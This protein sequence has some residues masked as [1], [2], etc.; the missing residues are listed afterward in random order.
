MSNHS[1]VRNL[2]DTWDLSCSDLKQETEKLPIRKYGHKTRTDREMQ[3]TLELTQTSM[4]KKHEFNEHHQTIS[5]NN[6]NIITNH[7]PCHD[8]VHWQNVKFTKHCTCHQ[9]G[10][11]EY[12]Q[13]HKTVANSFH[14]PLKTHQQYKP[15]IWN[16]P[17]LRDFLKGWKLKTSAQNLWNVPTKGKPIRE[18]DATMMHK[19]NRHPSATRHVS[20]RATRT[21]FGLQIHQRLRLP[22]KMTL[23]LHQILRLPRKMQTQ[24]HSAT[25]YLILW[26]S[27]TFHSTTF[28]YIPF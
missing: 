23:Q 11:R 2:Y 5:N 7:R 18:Y 15:T 24:R 28:Y 9:K 12:N 14:S 1:L 13:S 27:T 3:N 19:W 22:E 21:H 10:I 16:A 20:F 25:F 6:E 17:S 26:H 4:T 8:F